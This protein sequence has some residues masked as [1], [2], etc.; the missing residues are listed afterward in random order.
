MVLRPPTVV[1][2]VGWVERSETQQ[3]NHP[4]NRDQRHEPSTNPK[5]KFQ[6]PKSKLVVLKES[7]IGAK[8]SGV[9]GEGESATRVSYFKGN[10]PSQWKS[11]IATYNYANLGEVYEGITLKLK[12]HGNNVEKLFTV[13]P[14]ASPDQIKISLS[15]VKECGVRSAE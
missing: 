14:G 11:G 10:D 4:S 13:K 2:T 15:G 5:S 7:L 6:N 12:A 9:E 1:S 8:I 3:E